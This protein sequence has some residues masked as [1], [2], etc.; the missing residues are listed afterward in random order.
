MAMVGLLIML[1][2]VVD[3]GYARQDRRLAQNT[4]D[5]AAL[6]AAQDLDGTTG[7]LSVAVATAKSWAS[8]NDPDL[9]TTSWSGCRDV[10]ALPVRPDGANSCISFSADH[11]TVRVQLPQRVQPRFFAGVAGPGS[12]TLTARATATKSPAG[13]PSVP[14]GPCGLC[15]IGNSALQITN[16]ARI[17]VTGGEMQG[18][19]I[20]V[21][22]N[23]PASDLV[24]LPIRFFDSNN[25]NWGMNSTDPP[26]AARYSRLAAP[27]PN[28][29]DQV[30]VSYTGIPVDSSSNVSFSGNTCNGSAAQPLERN[31]VYRQTVRLNGGARLC[32]LPGTYYFGGQLEVNNNA[33]IF[34]E[35]VTLVFGSSGSAG[36]TFRQGSTVELTAPTTGPYA[37]LALLV[38]PSF[39]TGSQNHFQGRAVIKGAVYARGAGI[40]TQSSAVVDAWTIVVGGVADFNGGTFRIDNQA[41][42]DAAPGGGG[43]GGGSQ[44]S[45]SLVG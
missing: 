35:G 32:L 3:I 43:S 13:A 25:S 27:V 4:A 37:G 26:M 17:T 34:G 18:N 29:F 20:T 1:A 22:T 14:A 19:R 23:G 41:F 15:V 38:D 44:G 21:N 39:S 8:R 6:A 24:P 16:N 5:A 10:G 31:K 42:Y 45:V 36:W 28:P 33:Q 7:A 11:L 2:L 9:A 30:S 40:A 12:I